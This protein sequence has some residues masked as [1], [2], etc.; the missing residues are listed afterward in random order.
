MTDRGI[1]R[2]VCNV[3]II[4]TIQRDID[5]RVHAVWFSRLQE[6]RPGRPGCS[7]KAFEIAFVLMSARE[8]Y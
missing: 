2:H 4:V 5:G 3:Y 1:C 6:L 7:V 8:F